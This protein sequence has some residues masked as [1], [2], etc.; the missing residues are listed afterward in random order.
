MDK[1]DAIRKINVM[2]GDAELLYNDYLKSNNKEPSF[3][4]DVTTAFFHLWEVLTKQPNQMTRIVF[5]KPF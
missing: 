2:V 4:D 1:T 5:N 3:D